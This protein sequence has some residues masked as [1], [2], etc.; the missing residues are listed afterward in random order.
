MH[1][2]VRHVARVIVGFVSGKCHLVWLP[3]TWPCV[4]IVVNVMCLFSIVSLFSVVVCCV[5]IVVRCRVC[6]I[7]LTVMSRFSFVA[8]R[9]VWVARLHACVVVATLVCNRFS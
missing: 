9:R 8:A 1:Y 6:L 7:L 4:S 3:R 5:R 2:Y